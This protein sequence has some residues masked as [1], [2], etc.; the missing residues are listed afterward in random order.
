MAETTKKAKAPATPRK[1]GTKT[2]TAAAEAQ[3]AARSQVAA[4]PKPAMASQTATDHKLRAVSHDEIARL[5]HQ[6]WTERGYRHGNPE[7]DW[8]RA[9]QDLRKKAS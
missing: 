4:D 5:A 2:T 9:E 7:E 8:Y 6:Y 1:R 3:A